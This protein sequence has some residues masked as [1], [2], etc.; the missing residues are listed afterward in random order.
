MDDR[1][2][3]NIHKY[4][5]FG[6]KSSGALDLREYYL[7][8]FTDF[9]EIKFGKQIHS[10][11]DATGNNPTDNVNAYDYYFLFTTGAKRKIASLSASI[12]MYFDDFKFGVVILPEH[13][14]N[15]VPLNDSQFPIMDGIDGMPRNP[16]INSVKKP[17]EYGGYI[18]HSF[19]YSD[20]TLSYL[21]IHDRTFG[22]KGVNIWSEQTQTNFQGDTV[23]DYRSTEVVGLSG[24][25]MA[26]EF[27]FRLESALFK[28]QDSDL[29]DREFEYD[30]ATLCPNEVE[31]ACSFYTTEFTCNFQEECGWVDGTCVEVNESVCEVSIYEQLPL[32]TIAKYIQHIVQFE[33][34]KYDI[35]FNFQLFLHSIISIEGNDYFNQFTSDF[36]ID[37]NSKDYFTPGTGSP[38]AMFTDKALM[39]NMKKLFYDESGKELEIIW[40]NLIDLTSN[41]GFF[42]EIE[43]IYTISDNL[44][45]SF[46]LSKISG[47]DTLLNEDGSIDMSYPFNP[48]QDFS[49]T[50]FELRYFF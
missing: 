17:F 14:S 23:L 20:I 12:D 35:D 37:I 41:S 50:R 24:M 11:G 22:L 19:D 5:I 27:T 26:D 48:M 9:G 36:V 49:H 32:N 1:G 2:Y 18:S 3:V 45:L 31:D 40:K 15:R 16:I 46:A 39:F 13:V 34:T 6:I 38:I 30:S 29:S 25:V 43:S 44:K 4:K 8:Y 42:S 47:D 28:T 21:N 33:F 7:H 10:W